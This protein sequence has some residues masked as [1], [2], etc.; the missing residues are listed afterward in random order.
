[1]RELIKT[2]RYKAGY[3][4]RYEQ[5]TGDDAGGGPGFVMRSAWTPDGHYIGSPVIAHRLVK[6]IGIK[7]ELRTGP[8]EEHCGGHVCSIGFCEQDQ[9]WYGWS[10]RALFGFDIGYE[11][12]A[13]TA[14]ASSG[15]TDE[16]L[17]EHP[18]EDL[19]LPVGFVAKTL[20]DCRRLA[21]AFAENVG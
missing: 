13:G 14:C 21:I 4:I 15:W 16:Y 1:M 17:A 18:E 8:R 7:P 6:K 9:K 12:F 3:V 5:L 2:R 19:S 10:H 20:E 11:V